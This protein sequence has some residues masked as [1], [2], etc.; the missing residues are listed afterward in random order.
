MAVPK[1][2]PPN[3][4]FVPDAA[5]S[6]VLQW[7]H[8]SKLAMPFQVES[9][10]ASPVAALLVVDHD[11]RCKGVHRCL[12]LCAPVGS[13]RICLLRGFSIHYMFLDVPGPTSP[14]TL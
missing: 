10:L 1:G 14:W 7:G 6:E 2:A 5:G 8:A 11:P 4:L 3:T 13:P 12:V 9:H